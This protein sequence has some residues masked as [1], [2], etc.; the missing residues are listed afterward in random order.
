MIKALFAT[1]GIIL[2]S[3]LAFAAETLDADA[4]KKLLIGHTLHDVRLNG[5][6]VKSY[7]AADGKLYRQDDG[8][9]SEGTLSVTEDGH[10]CIGGVFGGCANIVHNDDGTYDRLLPDGKVFLKWDTVVDGK[11]F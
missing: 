11:D 5:T 10:Q 9:N 1:I 7:F 2:F 4:V 8:K 6:K 3:T